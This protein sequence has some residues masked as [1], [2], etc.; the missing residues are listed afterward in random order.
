MPR[1]RIERKRLTANQDRARP[2]GERASTVSTMPLP[3]MISDLRQRP[4]FFDTVADR[5]WRAWW[6]P[7]HYPLDH[8]IGRL[9]ENMNDPPI[10]LAL[11]AH[12]GEAFLGTASVIA[13]DLAERPQL[14]PWIAAVWVEPQAR[15]RGVGSALVNR[16]TQDC[17]ALGF[18]R[19]Y[20]CARP[21]RSA[22]YER[23]G[24]IPIER[25]VGP[26]HLLVFIRDA[27]PEAG[28]INRSPP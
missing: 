7:E 10:P 16:A 15:Q 22:L 27:D 5:I 13:S 3:F 9:R 19:V 6:Q 2:V 20:L 21:Q 17:S 14:T 18:S 23:L 28:R 1:D 25:D 12:D 24:W 8:I 11:V 26:H 4:E